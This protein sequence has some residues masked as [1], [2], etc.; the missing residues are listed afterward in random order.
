[1][2]KASPD[3]RMPRRFIDISNTMASTANNT[4]CWATSGTAEPMLDMAA[5]IET[6]TVRT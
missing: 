5:D 6:A 3:S 1:M 2:A 4:L